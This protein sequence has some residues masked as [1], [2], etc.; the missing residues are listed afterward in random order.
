[1]RRSSL[2]SSLPACRFLITFKPPAQFQRQAHKRLW[3]FVFFTPRF[4][5]ACSFVAMNLCLKIEVLY[6]SLLF[7]A[8]VSTKQ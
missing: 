3:A 8:N 6:K 1:M 4:R 5:A 7:H 2:S